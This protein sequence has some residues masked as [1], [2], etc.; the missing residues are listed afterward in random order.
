MF[1]FKSSNV[2]GPV[3]IVPMAGKDYSISFQSNS[4][5]L[6]F[7]KGGCNLAG[8]QEAQSTTLPQVEVIVDKKMCEL[9]VECFPYLL[10]LLPIR[11]VS[12]NLIAFSHIA[13]PCFDKDKLC[14]LFCCQQ[15]T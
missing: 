5:L 12:H 6:W 14:S 9:L 10:F 1:T 13:F 4:L 15:Q 2:V 8:I 11:H 7:S 3:L